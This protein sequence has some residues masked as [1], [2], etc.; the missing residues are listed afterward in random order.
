MKSELL[1]MQDNEL[2]IGTY[3]M[4]KGFCTTHSAV[5]KLITKYRERFERVGNRPLGDQILINQVGFEIRPKSKKKRVQELEFLLNEEQA[6]FLGTLLRN[7]EPV[8][9]FK[10][11]LV[12]E[13]RRM[14]KFILSLRNQRQNSEWL[15]KRAS[16][17]IERRVE[18]DS[19]KKFTEYAKNQGSESSSK[20]Y[21]AISKME[22]FALFHLELVKFEYSN[23]RDVVS[24]MGLDALKTADR[25]VA[26]ALEEGM[27][28]KFYY[29]EI[30]KL[31]KARVETF[32]DI[33]GKMYVDDYRKILPE[34]EHKHLGIGD[35]RIT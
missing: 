10:E 21:M 2:L 7:T 25:I 23:L 3:K 31:A 29:K 27:E 6:M 20:Y 12:S 15:E 26:R 33:F 11:R 22:N 24:G 34:N 4:S 17:K 14:Y 32:A 30:Y 28:K 18:T 13:F 35:L 8:L 9:K 16:G 19:I 1:I 5:K